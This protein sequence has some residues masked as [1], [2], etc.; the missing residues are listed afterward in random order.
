[1]KVGVHEIKLEKVTVQA[2]GTKLS[3]PSPKQTGKVSIS[4]S[5]NSALRDID[6]EPRIKSSYTI[7]D[8]PIQ[9]TKKVVMK[10][11]EKIEASKKSANAFEYFDSI[12]NT[13]SKSFVMRQA[14]MISSSSDNKKLKKGS[15]FEVEEI[16][17][18]D[19]C[20]T[21]DTNINDKAKSV[22]DVETLLEKRNGSQD[23]LLVEEEMRLEG[24]ISKKKLKLE[25]FSKKIAELIDIENIEDSDDVKTIQMSPEKSHAESEN[26][27]DLIE[28]ED[29]INQILRKK[30]KVIRILDDDDE[31]EKDG[32]ISE[33]SKGIKE[34][35]DDNFSVSDNG[36]MIEE[37]KTELRSPDTLR[38]SEE[39]F[40]NNSSKSSSP[41]Q[42]KNQIEQEKN[43]LKR[44][45]KIVDNRRETLNKQDVEKSLQKSHEQKEGKIETCPICLSILF[46]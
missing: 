45:K 7:E 41:K 34:K 43:K 2:N 39:C 44:L 21:N 17:Q 1:M 10:N 37:E 31:E 20:N 23:L 29:R 35:R 28:S 3:W 4:K 42:N 46:I 13:P 25:K 19:Y 11:K 5:S 32:I 14:E 22:I 40:L 33:V 18:N 15:P 6:D 36:K 38:D 30:K 8:S 26:F 24:K 12:I 16:S 9:S 27:K